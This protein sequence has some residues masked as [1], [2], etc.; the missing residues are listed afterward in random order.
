M[1]TISSFSIKL[2]SREYPPLLSYIPNPPKVF[3]CKGQIDDE[4]FKNCLA[5]VG[6]RRM[7]SYG[8]RVIKYL[9]STFSKNITI[10]SGF[11]RGVDAEAHNQA[12]NFGLKTIAVL[13]CGVDYVHPE[14]QIDL[15]KKIILKGGVI[16]SEYC[17][18]LKPD[19]WMYPRRNRIVAGLS[20]AVLVVESSLNSGSLITANLAKSFNRPVFV[21][22]GSI[23]SE[24]SKGNMKISNE[25]AISVGSSS[26]INEFMNLKS[27]NNIKSRQIYLNL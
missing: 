8:K 3:Y 25:F 14:Y 21:I 2:G 22:P 12:I 24:T 16:F 27:S 19:I 1:N 20:K 26:Y 10:V 15:Y 17:G 9:F 23:F 4:I 5:V 11:M 18:N 7:S 6:S 13:P